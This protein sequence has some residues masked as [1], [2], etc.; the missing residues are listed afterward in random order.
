M[1][2]ELKDFYIYKVGCRI[3]IDQEDCIILKNGNLLFG[4]CKR[5]N[6]DKEGLI[7]FFCNSKEEVDAVYR[8][9]KTTADSPPSMNEKYGIYQ[10]FMRDPEG[11]KLEFQYFNHRIEQYLSG[12]ELLLTRRSIRR[13]TP[14]SI[15]DDILNQVLNI[16]RFAPTARNTQ[17]YYFK[18]IEDREL[19]RKLSE[20]RGKSSSPIDK[21]PLAIAICSDPK[22]SKRYIQDGCIAA[23]H[24]MLSAWYYGLGTCWIAAMDRD[25][26]K[27]LLEI[28]RN[29]YVVTVTPLGYPEGAIPSA[30][31][32]KGL[33]WF[34]RE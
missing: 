22:I 20:V 8:K 2:E 33:E 30:P 23:Y 15:P 16:S 9:F 31:E 26:V 3:W 34:L 10:F 29:H 7:T 12:D 28:D 11:R 14:K 21:A 17:P 27:D 1:L 19:I 13:F 18:I 32:R 5:D 6:P 4:F 24:F 25:E